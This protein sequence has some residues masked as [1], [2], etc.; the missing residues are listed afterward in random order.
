MANVYK[1]N[2]YDDD[3]DDWCNMVRFSRSDSNNIY[4]NFIHSYIN[5]YI[6][7]LGMVILYNN[8]NNNN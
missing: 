6:S 8:H 5:M 7:N 4:S 3:Y 2:I 1:S